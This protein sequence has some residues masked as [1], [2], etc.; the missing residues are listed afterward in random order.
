MGIVA[1]LFPPVQIQDGLLWRESVGDVMRQERVDRGERLTDV[2]GRAGVSPQYL[3]EIE[4]GMKDP[5]SEMLHAIAG[6]LGLEVPDL[7]RRAAD[8]M[9]ATLSDCA[10][11]LAA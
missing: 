8:T 6:A 7:A 4:R 3:S 11:V 2:A 5:S 9:E 10:V 1:P